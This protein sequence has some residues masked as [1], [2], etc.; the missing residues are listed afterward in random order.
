MNAKLSKALLIV[1]IAGAFWAP[2]ASAG[3]F[4]LVEVA[5]GNLDDRHSTGN[6]DGDNG[7]DGD[8]TG[9]RSIQGTQG[10][11][12]TIEVRILD[13]LVQLFGADEG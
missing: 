3:V 8:G 13:L 2:V 1:L 4:Q 9:D 7:D 5:S 11:Q 6:N 12:P 10:S